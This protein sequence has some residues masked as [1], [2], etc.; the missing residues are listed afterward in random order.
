MAHESTQENVLAVA[1]VIESSWPVYHQWAVVMKEY[2]SLVLKRLADIH[3]SIKMRVAL[4]VYG[5]RELPFPSPLYKRFFADYQAAFREV[6]EVSANLGICQANSEDDNGMAALEGLVA[7][8][9]LFDAL[10]AC[11]QLKGRVYPSYIFH[12][13][14]RPSDSSQHPQWNDCTYLDNTTW[15][16]LPQEYRKRNIIYNAILLDSQLCRF[17]SLHSAMQHNPYFDTKPWFPVRKSHMVLLSSIPVPSES[18]NMPAKRAGDVTT[19]ERTP[20]SK[21]PR[22]VLA[23]ADVLPQQGSSTNSTQLTRSEIPTT[24]R[25]PASSA[26]H[27]SF[28]LQLVTKIRALEEKV[29]ALESKASDARLAGNSALAEKLT[30]EWKHQKEFLTNSQK[31]VRE[32]VQVSNTNNNGNNAAVTKSSPSNAIAHAPQEIPSSSLSTGRDKQNSSASTY[33]YPQGVESHVAS[34]QSL[35]NP[36]GLSQSQLSSVSNA[37][38]VLRTRSSPITAQMHKLIE[39]DQRN[40][41]LQNSQLTQVPNSLSAQVPQPSQSTIPTSRGQQKI[42]SAVVWQGQLIWNGRGP[43]GKKECRSNVVALSQNVVE[44]RAD[45]WPSSLALVPTHEPAVSLPELKEWIARFKP[46]ICRFQP[47]AESVPDLMNEQYYKSLIQVLTTKRVYAVAGWTLPS[48]AQENNVL[49]FPVNDIA[50]LGAFFPVAGI[51]EMPKPRPGTIHPSPSPHTM[52]FLAQ[53]QRLPP[54]QRDLF[55]AQMLH[56]Q[57][58][59]FPAGVTQTAT[60]QQALQTR[61]TGLAQSQM[62]SGRIPFNLHEPMNI[63]STSAGNPSPNTAMNTPMQQQPRSGNHNEAVMQMMQP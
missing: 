9:E 22:L 55:V 18:K 49:V 24:S 41:P 16:T 11:S 50:L 7:A 36:N 57:T 63:A 31:R 45:T 13:A 26:A 19:I 28:M 10:R 62:G 56:K 4:I 51:P 6:Q 15:L 17:I 23:Q 58:N 42:S 33:E 46:V 59:Q 43:M 32:F 38:S 52:Q 25:T 12:I 35:I 40:R 29:R 48:G 20:E 3:S 21:R 61:I 39:Q 47:K 1:L 14:A 53:L 27:Y 54:D 8:I 34:Q 30:L 2:L 44:C 37:G 60:H 5:S